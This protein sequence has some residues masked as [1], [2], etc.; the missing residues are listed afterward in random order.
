[1]ALDVG[2][3][4][5]RI[6]Q[7]SRGLSPWD[8]AAEA[9][10]RTWRR[11]ST[12][13]HV[14]VDQPSSTCLTTDDLSRALSGRNITEISELI[15][16]RDRVLLPGLADPDGTANAIRSISPNSA[17]DMLADAEAILEHR[18]RVFGERY[19]FGGEIDWHSDPVTGDSWP[20]NHFSRVPVIIGSSNSDQS[21]Q[22]RPVRG[23][24]IRVVW[25]L[26]RLHH[27][28]TLGQA[29]AF[30]RD[31]RFTSEFLRQIA[32]WRDQNP[33]RFGPNWKTAMEVAIRAVNVVAAIG[34]FRKSS[35]L[36]DEDIELLLK[37]LLEHGRYIRG[38]LE[39][40]RG[41]SSNHYLSDL[42]GLF[43]IAATIPWFRESREWMNLASTELLREMDQQVLG[44]G[45]DYEGATGYH[46]LVTEI[47]GLFFTLSR[48]CDE[49]IPE[50][51]WRRLDSMFDFVRH[52]IK[53]D[54]T[55]PQLGDSDDG[56]LLSFKQRAPSDHTYLLSVAAVLFD[57]RK[58]RLGA[59]PDE[60]AVWWFGASC[61]QDFQRLPNGSPA[62]SAEFREA[63]IFIQ[64][65]NEKD[66][67][68]I[69]DC[70]DNGTRG[71][72]SHAHCDALSIELFAFGET[73]L[74][75]PGTFAYTGG[76][77]WRNRFRSTA[78]HNTARVDGEEIS[79]LV[80]GWYFALGSNVRP[81]V[82]TWES[83][84]ERDVL[85]AEHD[86]YARLREP[87]THR[88]IVTLEK[89][90]G[91]WIVDDRFEG[92]GEHTFELTF[93]FAPG[94]EISEREAGQLVARGRRG[95]L[96]IAPISG[97]QLVVGRASRWVSHS[98]GTASQASAMIYRFRL[99]VP[100]ENTILLIPCAAGDEAK[101]DR[102]LKTHVRNMRSL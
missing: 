73:L 49:Q 30:S 88:R 36:T 82:N 80:D 22:D 7:R 72:G 44:D 33:P 13:W 57:D 58:Y 89:G 29:Y 18:I 76:G 102:V 70:G 63:R 8:L 67:Y 27:L 24:D 50:R 12:T 6:R 95:S 84:A 83:S 9:A 91:Y 10:T 79:P 46:R 56:R 45:A 52:Y 40:R 75:D 59:L 25:E 77:P 3:A 11:A 20:P 39:R 26:N 90:G 4:I 93:N 53:P 37:F 71:H 21:K 66:L 64:R 74:C 99:S 78:F 85:D 16:H 100:F 69:I 62:E 2:D 1:M 98:Y 38:N 34:L 41:G 43:A 17:N 61:I 68:A 32:D 101:A 47:Y 35:Y 86:G 94:I 42:V 60:E 87:V 15:H 28:V 48:S 23:P 97:H 65:A 51:Y 14:A 55:A 5:R 19:E 81:R 54:G 92:Q 96:T 31:E